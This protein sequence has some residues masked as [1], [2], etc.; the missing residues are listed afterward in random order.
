VAVL[1]GGAETIVRLESHN[2]AVFSASSYFR[3]ITAML[4]LFATLFSVLAL[5]MFAPACSHPQ[6]ADISSWSVQIRTSGGFIGIGRGNVLVN[7]EGKITYVKPSPPGKT[8]R[9]CEG[10]LS[11]EEV[12]AISEA[13]RQSKPD[14]WR[15]S[16]PNVGAPDAYGYDLELIIDG[17]AHKIEWYD[18]TQDKL[19]GDLQKLY[20]TVNSATRAAVKKCEG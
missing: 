14:Q 18:N 4:H 8:A 13:V 17:K 9:P 7:S 5:T 2:Q 1:F 16:G 6:P 19:P 10:K 3:V 20:G 12:R 11:S 15:I